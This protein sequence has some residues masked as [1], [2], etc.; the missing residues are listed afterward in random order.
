MVDSHDITLGPVVELSEG[1]SPYSYLR[2]LMSSGRGTRRLKMS[3]MTDELLQMAFARGGYVAGGFARVVINQRDIQDKTAD[4][5][6]YA[7]IF[8]NYLNAGCVIAT[9]D[10]NENRSKCDRG[11]IDIFFREEDGY[12][13]FINDLLLDDRFQGE[14]G[15]SVD[16]ARS[17]RALNLVVNRTVLIQAVKSHFGPPEDVLGAFDIDNAKVAFDSTRTWMVEGWR[18][19]ERTSTLSCT[20]WKSVYTLWRVNKWI[21]RHGHSQLTRET[22]AAAVRFALD[23]HGRLSI[24]GPMTT[25]PNYN[26][27][28]VLTM[29]RRLVKNCMISDE[30]FL[31]L[32]AIAPDDDYD[33]SVK[34]LIRKHFPVT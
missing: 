34:A 11:D 21:R 20:L 10:L 16:W 8:D 4:F 26:C 30:Q 3:S 12:R 23:L 22:S 19:L 15:T 25:A 24:D 5:E 31:L 2:E 28:D 17:P 32:T 9:S 7:R 27:D 1:E 33:L 6:P 18:S 29:V 14:K 13:Q